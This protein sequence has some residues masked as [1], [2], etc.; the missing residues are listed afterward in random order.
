MPEVMSTANRMRDGTVVWL[1]RELMWSDDPSLAAGFVDEAA[2]DARDE[3]S[4][5]T[6]RNE[7]VAAYEIR[8]DGRQDRSMRE[9]IRAGR[10]PTITLPP[11]SPAQN[12]HD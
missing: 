10:G 9:R 5:A 12:R 3:A 6:N 8:I 7:I 1:T 2:D 4:A 11:N